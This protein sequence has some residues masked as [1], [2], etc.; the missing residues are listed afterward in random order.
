MLLPAAVRDIDV[1]VQS[2]LLEKQKE[3]SK[4]PWIVSTQ[5]MSRLE[6]K[7]ATTPV[8]EAKFRRRHTS[9]VKN[10]MAC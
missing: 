1:D 6:E 5:A 7:N 2:R 4:T 10:P 3:R 8:I 9:L